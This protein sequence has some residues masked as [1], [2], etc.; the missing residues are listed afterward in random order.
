M[1]KKEGG[2]PK[3]GDAPNVLGDEIAKWYKTNAKAMGVSYV[4]WENNIWNTGEPMGPGKSQGKS[5]CTYAHWD[6]VHV[7]YEK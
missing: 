2:C 5:G 1:L 3:D 6:H 4:I 7:S